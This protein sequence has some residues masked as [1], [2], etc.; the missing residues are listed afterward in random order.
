MTLPLPFMAWEVLSCT[1]TS[2]SAAL[3]L[4][5]AMM[6]FQPA[7][8][9]WAPARPWRRQA[10]VPAM[11]DVVSDVPSDMADD[12]Q[13]VGVNPDGGAQISRL[14]EVARETDRGF[15]SSPEQRSEIQKLLKE[16]TKDNPMIM[17]NTALDGDCELYG[18]SSIAGGPIRISCS[19]EWTS[20]HGLHPRPAQGSSCG[21]THQTFSDCGGVR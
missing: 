8:L 21:L 19:P 18:P 14:L 15:S 6:G 11:C 20:N 5:A 4:S 12:E 7:S 16:L 9:A 13:P 17:G 3:T 10:L 2:M 1:L